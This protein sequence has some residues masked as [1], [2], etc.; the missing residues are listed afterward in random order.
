MMLMLMLM[1]N[2]C[3]WRCFSLFKLLVLFAVVC[4]VCAGIDVKADVDV[5]FLDHDYDASH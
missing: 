4:V 2:R 5:E 3:C 1:S